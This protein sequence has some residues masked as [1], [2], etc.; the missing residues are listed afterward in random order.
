MVSKYCI[1]A[2]V[3]SHMLAEDVIAEVYLALLRFDIGRKSQRP[4][5]TPSDFLYHRSYP[6]IL[7]SCR[8]W[9]TASSWKHLHSRINP[10][11]KLNM[12]RLL[13]CK[14]VFNI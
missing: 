4:H 5:S 2:S 12:H 11:V 13:D 14:H 1:Q 8:S 3:F 6:Y 10:I 7:L 9:D